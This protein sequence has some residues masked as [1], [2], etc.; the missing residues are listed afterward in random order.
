[1]YWFCYVIGKVGCEPCRRTEASGFLDV[2]FLVLRKRE[3]L[4]AVRIFIR[5]LFV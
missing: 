5:Y 1:M 3:V 4:L 2:C